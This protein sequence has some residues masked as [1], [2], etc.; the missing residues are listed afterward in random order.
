MYTKSGQ[1]G[2]GTRGSMRKGLIVKKGKEDVCFRVV[3]Q[4]RHSDWKT[5]GVNPTEFAVN[6]FTIRVVPTRVKDDGERFKNK[7]TSRDLVTEGDTNPHSRRSLV[8][9]G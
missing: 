7:A 2:R 4:V 8:T 5:K 1:N 6:V 9:F 3:P